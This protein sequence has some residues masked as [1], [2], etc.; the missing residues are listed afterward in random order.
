M[1][2][3][4]SG[5][6]EAVM[7]LEN[8]KKTVAGEIRPS[9]PAGEM[10]IFT[11]GHRHISVHA[12]EDSDLIK[13]PKSTF[14]T[15]AVES[16]RF[17]KR[18]AAISRRRLRKNQ[19]ITILSK[20]LGPLTAVDLDFIQKH[21]RWVYLKRGEVLFKQN[22]PGD[23][24]CVLISGRLVAA[25]EDDEGNERIVGEIT[26][27]ELVGEMSILTGISR[28]ASVYAIRDS[29]L[30]LFSNET[31]QELINKYPQV[32][33]FTAR[34]IINRLNKTMRKSSDSR[35]ISSIAV[36]PANPRVKLC[37]FVDRLENSL[38]K[39]TP[40]LRLNSAQ[41][42]S[43]IGIQGI[44][45][46]TE[47]N[48]YDNR[49]STALDEQATK[50]HLIIYECD[51]S[52][53]P[54]TK[55]CIRQADQIM[56][57]ANP[58]DNSE[59][60]PIEKAFLGYDN[61]IT[62]AKQVLVLMHP[63]QDIPPKNTDLW[64]SSR[65][66]ESHYHICLNREDDYQRLAR[67][68]TGNAVGLVLGGG[69]ARGFAHVG[70]VRALQEEGVPIDMIGGCSMGAVIAA[71]PALRWDYD[72]ILEINNR[73][74]V[75]S[76][77]IRDYTFPAVSIV[78][79]KKLEKF[80]KLGFGSKQIEDL[81]ITYF[82]VSSNLSTAETVVHRKGDIW[83]AVRTSLSIPG[84]FA[85]VLHGNDLLVD[86][87]LLNNLPGD[88]MTNMCKG[89]VIAVD[90]SVKTDFKI[91]QDTMPSAWD[92]IRNR[93]RPSKAAEHIP[94][95]MD[96]MTRST[97]LAS[98]SKADQVKSSVDFYLRPPVDEVGLLDFSAFE[99]IADIGYQHTKEEIQKW[100]QDSSV[101]FI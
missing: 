61:D 92:V 64:L 101:S 75:E 81:W 38:L 82:C 86:G 47:T 54:W 35:L 72:T 4:I 51:Q 77:P 39:Y 33:V 69:G 3:A 34:T 31:I 91:N 87:C 78:K 96:I 28:S 5:K 74:F 17:V 36:V 26:Q 66:V 49:L 2:I 22:D 94:S 40:I 44:S 56:I 48:P 98:T 73:F 62:A 60:G 68:V 23:S 58:N 29:V 70:V 41:L 7:S 1:Y 10:Q 97:L 85:P 8:Q 6:L 99:E 37:D 71:Q 25:R 59:P 13:L 42:D 9:E 21:T 52:A 15:L 88:I 18:M 11:G 16:P 27:G 53:T 83:K 67:I 80:L 55:R 46:T 45:Q 76:N 57:I 79:G 24:L 20:F 12:V 84:M 95:I 89:I 14:E 50:Q 90:V 93:I 100:K 63:D 19:V 43:L 65:H 32:M 30:A